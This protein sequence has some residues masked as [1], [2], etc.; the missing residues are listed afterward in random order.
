[1]WGRPW[2]RSFCERD[3]DSPRSR[4]GTVSTGA[5][6]CHVERWWQA[7]GGGG[8]GTR[9]LG[10]GWGPTERP[11]LH[12][13]TRVHRTP[14]EAQNPVGGTDVTDSSGRGHWRPSEAA[15]L[16]RRALG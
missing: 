8:S 3:A 13:S 16:L 7:A 9:L 1:M 6:C 12:R 2:T 14:L 11:L 15:L 10:P 5:R 4:L